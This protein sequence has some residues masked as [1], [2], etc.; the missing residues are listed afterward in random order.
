MRLKPSRRAFLIS[1]FSAGIALGLSG[2]WALKVSTT[3]RAEMVALIVRKKLSYLKLDDE[4]VNAFARDAVQRLTQSENARL[5]WLRR[6]R[7]IYNS[8][9]IY[10]YSS[11]AEKFDRFEERLAKQYLMSSDF[12]WNES[13]ETRTVAYM[14]YYDPYAG[15][16]C[17]NPFASFD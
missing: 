17:A 6:V 7:P 2:W 5:D 15:S 13:D 4:G 1:S 11:S 12:F 3:D 9:D 16:A 8:I 14:S 10:E